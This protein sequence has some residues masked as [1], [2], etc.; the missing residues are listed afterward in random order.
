MPSLSETPAVM[1]KG[2]IKEAFTSPEEEDE[3]EEPPDE[4]TRAGAVD[5]A[6]LESVA[7]AAEA[8][9]A[10]VMKVFREPPPNWPPVP[11]WELPPPKCPRC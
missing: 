10:T 11:F 6:G 9:E 3:E 7:L 2:G 8:E 4:G 5:A 1:P